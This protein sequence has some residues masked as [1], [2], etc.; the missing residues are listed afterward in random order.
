MGPGRM[1]PYGP[2]V[3]LI[4]GRVRRADDEMKSSGV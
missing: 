3:L 4:Q 1:T 2:A